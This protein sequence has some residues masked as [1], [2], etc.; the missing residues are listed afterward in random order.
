MN[1]L[2]SLFFSSKTGKPC[3]IYGV[4]TI[5]LNDVNSLF[6]S[7]TETMIPENYII[8]NVSTPVTPLQKQKLPKEDSFRHPESLW[9]YGLYRNEL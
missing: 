9:Q 1:P 8:V 2:F 7:K 3:N 6:S 5:L 4:S